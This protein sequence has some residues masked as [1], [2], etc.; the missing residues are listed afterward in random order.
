MEHMQPGGVPDFMH[1]NLGGSVFDSFPCAVVVWNRE[2]RATVVNR[3]AREMF[4][5]EP[6]E[7][8]A[9]SSLWMDGIHA[10]DGDLFRAAWN[11]LMAGEKRISCDYRFIRGE[12]KFWIRDVSVCR[13]GDDGAGR[14]ITSVYADVSDLHRERRRDWDDR[15]FEEIGDIIDSMVHGIKNDLQIIS[16][17]FDLMCLTTGSEVTDYQS[18]LESIQRISRTILELR[19]FFS[20]R[21][22]KFSRASPK[23]IL[24]ELVRDTQT[25]LRRQ[26][27]ELRVRC[28]GAM[29]LVRLDWNEFRTVLGQVI[30]FAGF[31]LPSG[32]QLELKIGVQE[33]QGKHQIG[34]Q[35]SCASATSLTIKEND[36]FRPFLKVNGR[37]AGLGIALAKQILGRHNG[38]ISFQKPNP[39]RGLFTISLEAN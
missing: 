23:A 11:K 21:E 27:I 31:L 4:G 5:F 22:P 25:K 37:Q 12:K 15:R 14:T 30:E 38:D 35:I 3:A 19:E 17:G 18:L 13:D 20:P 33:H 9:K 16:S 26:N 6:G 32:G 39:R 34:L 10:E 8:E 1:A 2:R 24:E 7:L 29:P 28:Q 36:V